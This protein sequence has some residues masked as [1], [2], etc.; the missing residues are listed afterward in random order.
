MLEV[1]KHRFTEFKYHFFIDKFELTE[2]KM[3]TIAFK[4]QQKDRHS[5]KNMPVPKS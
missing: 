4:N 3:V 1:Q 5:H 2:H